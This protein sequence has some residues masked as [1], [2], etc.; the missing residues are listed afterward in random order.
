[1]TYLLA[2]DQGT[3]SSRSIVF[4]AHGHI[5]AQAQLELPQIYPRPGWVEHDPMAIWRTQLATAREALQKASLCA[6]V[7]P[8]DIRALGI[9]NQRETT[10]LWN[11]RTG[12]PVHHAIVWQDRRA[13]STCAQ[14]RS[15]GHEAMIQSKTGL[16]IDAY[17]SGTKLKWLLDNVPS[18]RGQAERGELAFGTVDS[19]LMWQLT[20]GT[21][22]A[23]D[24]SNAART[25][26]FNVHTNQWDVELLDLLG[27]PASLMPQVQPSSSHFGTVLPELLGRAIPIGGVAGDQQ[28][29]LFGQACFSAGMAKNTY[30]TGCFML[31]HTGQQFQTSANGLLTTS[32]AQISAQTEFAIEGSVFVGGAVVQW[33]RDG[34]NAIK[35]SAEVQALAESVPD[36]G[37]VMMV[38]AFTGLGAPYWQPDA[39]GT[40]TGLTRGTTVAHIARAALESIAY[41]SA[42]LLQAMSRDAVAS[43][44]APVAQLRVDGGACVNDLLMQFQADLLG[45]PVVRP[46][47]TE[48]TALGAAY[49]A[50]LSS[51][52]YG[53]VADL[54]DLWQV[55]R[56]FVP[57]L[58]RGRADEL[59]QRWE[60]A[61][62][63]ATAP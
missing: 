62:R 2:L 35:G 45:I 37:G 13:E 15:G 51:G 59:M 23:T 55:E 29:A 61:V 19:W 32:A 22:H 16:L 1:M 50:G 63:Q 54:T 26:L 57:L 25:L 11:R 5:V 41:Q 40:I 60:H 49:L 18:A 27:I 52:V 56:T 8:S 44:A 28:S 21:V 7:K 10:V 43:G 20:G 3:S 33:L 24:V 42:A 6:G 12:Q 58:P 39:R 38:P 30:G 31:M 47:V 4:D 36:A 9:T 34:L 48:T 46:A 53:G 17:F 14:L